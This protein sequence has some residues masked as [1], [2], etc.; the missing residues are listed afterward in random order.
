MKNQAFT[1]IELLVVILII[2]VLAAIALPR[3]HVLVRKSELV[4][5]LPLLNRVI[6][7]EERYFLS[8]GK[9]ADSLEELDISMPAGFT[10][11]GTGAT[12]DGVTI[13]FN[14]NNNSDSGIMFNKYARLG[15]NLPPSYYIYHK[16]RSYGIC[17]VNPKDTVGNRVCQAIGGVFSGGTADNT[18]NRYK[19]PR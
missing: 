8:N 3:Y 2:G 17:Q 7:S 4:S 10:V 11:T 16:N 9:Y 12:K 14:K 13:Y 18:W 1:L 15:G 19:V 5:L 6:Q